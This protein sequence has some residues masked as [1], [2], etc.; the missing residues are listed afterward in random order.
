MSAPSISV[1]H[2]SVKANPKKGDLKREKDWSFM[3][4]SFFNLSSKAFWVL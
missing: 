2:T 1:L 3:K 4:V